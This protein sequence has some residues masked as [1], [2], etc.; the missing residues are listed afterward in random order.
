MQ[1]PLRFMSLIRFFG[2]LSGLFFPSLCAGCLHPLTESEQELCL[3]CNWVLPRTGY[4]D[5]SANETSLRLA[6]RFRFEQASSFL[7]F[8]QDGLTQNLLHQIKYEG[9]KSLAT[10]LAMLFAGEL[11]ASGWLNQI[12]AVIP[13][14]LHPRKQAKRGFNQSELLA[15]ALAK[16]ADKELLTGMLIRRHFTETQTL[17]SRAE[18]LDN[19]KNAFSLVSSATANNKHLLL[20]DDVLTTGA[21]IEACAT[22][23]AEIPGMRLSVATL[24]IAYQ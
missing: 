4:H 23:L 12:D 22:A 14:P 8:T 6:G 11:Q 5:L 21:T 16:A 18:R 17:K 19:L 9:R 10:Y 2:P 7:Y 1:L 13:V 15:A 24:A 20:V 3:H